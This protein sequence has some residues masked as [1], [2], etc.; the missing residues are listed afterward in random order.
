[1]EYKCLAE[2]PS[3]E[4]L[5]REFLR[6]PKKIKWG[7]IGLSFENYDLFKAREN[8]KSILTWIFKGENGKDADY[9][10]VEPRTTLPP[11][12]P[13][14]KP[15]GL[16]FKFEEEWNFEKFRKQVLERKLKE[17]YVISGYEFLWK[18]QGFHLLRYD[19]IVIREKKV[20]KSGWI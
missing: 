13:D 20:W 9:S 4:E 10:K 3:Q 17:G 12:N 19:A 18:D 6:I 5:L 1:M 14:D 7:L 16:C 11:K 8:G 15:V 2:N